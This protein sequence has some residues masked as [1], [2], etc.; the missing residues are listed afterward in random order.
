M[1]LVVMPSEDAAEVGERLV[2]HRWMRTLIDIL[3]VRGVGADRG[4]VVPRERELGCDTHGAEGFHRRI[5]TETEAETPIDEPDSLAGYSATECGDR[6]PRRRCDKH[7]ARLV[8]AEVVGVQQ[9]ACTG[10]AE[11]CDGADVF[12]KPPG[13]PGVAC[14][15]RAVRMPIDVIALEATT[16]TG[17]GVS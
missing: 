13:T 8:E 2:A 11:Q 12:T 14:R 5:D 7:L 15:G 6:I 4:F 1:N 3:V 10:R 16:V 17:P 9:I